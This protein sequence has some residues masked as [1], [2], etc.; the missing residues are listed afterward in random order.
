[1]KFL[2]KKG[3]LALTKPEER[4]CLLPDFLAGL[5][6]PT[7]RNS[8]GFRLIDLYPALS[9][10]PLFLGKKSRMYYLFLHHSLCLLSGK[11]PLSFH[12]D[13]MML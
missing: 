9:V 7:A 5:L 11:F 3:I 2:G 4:Y 10:F 12:L 13:V 1:M 8:F 6:L